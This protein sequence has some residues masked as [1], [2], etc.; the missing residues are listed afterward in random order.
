MARVGTSS[1]DHMRHSWSFPLCWLALACGDGASSTPRAEEK[2]DAGGNSQELGGVSCESGN[3]GSG[4]GTCR[5][6][7]ACSDGKARSLACDGQVCECIEGDARRPLPD[8][9]DCKLGLAATAEVCGFDVE[10]DAVDAG[11]PNGIDPVNGCWTSP[12]GC[13]DYRD[14][15]YFKCDTKL[16][17]DPLVLPFE[18][19]VDM[20]ASD[21]P[22]R[23]P[24][25]GEALVSCMLDALRAGKPGSLRIE[26][27]VALGSETT[28]I[29]ILE[30]GGA[31]FIVNN[32]YDNTCKHLEV[33]RK[34]KSAAYFEKCARTAD[35]LFE[36]VNAGYEDTCIGTP[37]C[38]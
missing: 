32:W 17:C 14:I 7:F 28:E 2:P 19:G 18:D 20:F 29:I 37:V 13:P 22:H 35:A 30:D 33:A 15:P 36:C 31:V 8:V 38:K 21:A 12:E 10:I 4:D 26:R 27:A 24:E 1:E 16:L 9:N 11:A 5:S 34:L 3:G 23:L 6:D 25:N